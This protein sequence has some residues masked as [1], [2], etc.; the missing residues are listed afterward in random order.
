MFEAAWTKDSSDHP[1]PRA[2]ASRTRV[3]ERGIFLCACQCARCQMPKSAAK[4]R[5]FS[6]RLSL[7]LQE[8]PTMKEGHDVFHE[9]NKVLTPV[10]NISRQQRISKLFSIENSQRPLGSPS[11]H[12]GPRTHARA[13]EVGT[14]LPSMFPPATRRHG[15][16]PFLVSR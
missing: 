14:F 2:C 13:E 4:E 12:Q 15:C 16:S 3:F 1:P 7:P 9:C 11:Q 10:E 8:L 6:F 5:R